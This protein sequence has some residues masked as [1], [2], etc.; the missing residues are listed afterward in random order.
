MPRKPEYD[1]NKERLVAWVHPKTKKRVESRAKAEKCSK[2]KV[3]D[4]LSD[5]GKI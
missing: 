2:G 3:L 4:K 1:V 5:E